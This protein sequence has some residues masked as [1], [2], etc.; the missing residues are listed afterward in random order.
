MCVG[1]GVKSRPNAGRDAHRKEELKGRNGPRRHACGKRKEKKR[2]GT[3]SRREDMDGGV[4]RHAVLVTDRRQP[5]HL[6]SFPQEGACRV[7]GNIKS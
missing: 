6:P 2:G 1:G 5:K 7:G 3:R 4:G